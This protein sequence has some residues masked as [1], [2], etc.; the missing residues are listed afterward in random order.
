M[1]G[2]VAGLIKESKSASDI[3]KDLM[4]DAQRVLDKKI[5]LL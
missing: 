5:E 2:E 1:A 3:V 4:E